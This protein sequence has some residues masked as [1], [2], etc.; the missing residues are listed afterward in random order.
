MP[1]ALAI[2]TGLA[3]GLTDEAVQKPSSSCLCTF[4]VARLQ[5]EVAALPDEAWV[6]H[7]DRVPG[8]SAT[9]LLTAGGQETD[10]IHGQML[11]TRWLETMPYVR[12]A[13]ASFGVIWGRPGP[14]RARRRAPAC[15]C[16]PTSNYNWHCGY[17]CTS[18]S[19][20]AAGGLLLPHGKPCIWVAGEAWIPDNWRQHHVENKSDA[21]RIHLV[22]DMTGRM[23]SF[24]AICLVARRS[25]SKL[26]ADLVMETRRQSR[27]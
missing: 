25:P 23:A 2:Q 7:P 27:A 13:L 18:R 22:A 26:P 16:M 15:P 3:A 21:A 20:P 9:R 19:L 24:L 14:M 6:P 1:A 8:N 12:Q 11:P 5:A 4:D 10:T 17:A